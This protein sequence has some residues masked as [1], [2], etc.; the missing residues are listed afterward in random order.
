M[1]TH[2]IHTY[3]TYY[4]FYPFHFHHK[5]HH[6]TIPDTHVRVPNESAMTE[7][8]QGIQCTT[9]PLPSTYITF[10]YRVFCIKKY[11]EMIKKGS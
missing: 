5:V 4:T 9:Q 1:N 8:I 6:R 10:T 2:D 3:F 11:F 7:G